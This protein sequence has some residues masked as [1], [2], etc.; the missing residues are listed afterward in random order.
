MSTGD[1][2]EDGAPGPIGAS[3][4]AAPFA[5][6]GKWL[7]P[8][9]MGWGVS[10]RRFRWLAGGRF[11]RVDG[12]RPQDA[13]TLVVVRCAECG[14]VAAYVESWPGREELVFFIPSYRFRLTFPGAKCPKHGF[15]ADGTLFRG[16]V[17]MGRDQAR[18]TGK[19]VTVRVRC[20]KR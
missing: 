18:N 19:R 4:I 8:T 9:D 10:S 15:P 2:D 16:R 1:R 11:F 7:K 3:F 6:V 13:K 5:Q 17:L 12:P 14:K 20:G